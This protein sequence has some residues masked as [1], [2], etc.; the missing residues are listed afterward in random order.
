[1]QTLAEV[2]G[3]ARA[4][5]HYVFSGLV[6]TTACG[7]G[8]PALGYPDDAGAPLATTQIDGNLQ[9][10]GAETPLAPRIDTS[11]GWGGGLEG[12]LSAWTPAGIAVDAQGRLLVSGPVTPSGSPPQEVIH[13]LAPDGTPDTSF[14]SAGRAA[15]GVSASAWQQTLRALPDGRVGVIGAMSS[16]AEN[17]TFAARLLEDGSMDSAFHTE[18]VVAAKAGTFS[19]GLWAD[20]GAAFIFGVEATVSLDSGGT[21]NSSYGSVGTLPS[22]NAGALTEDGR[23][24][25]C[26]DHGIARYEKS[27]ALDLTFGRGGFVDISGPAGGAGVTSLRQLA[28]GVDGTIAAV[29]SH[30]DATSFYVD[31]ARLGPSGSLDLSY[32]QGGWVSIPVSSGPVGA[33]YL[34]DRRLLVWT[35]D[36]GLVLV[37]RNGQAHESWDLDVRGTVLAAAL[38]TNERLVMIGTLTDSPPFFHWF[39]RRF[40]LLDQTSPE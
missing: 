24:L 16:G 13:R 8:P 3:N 14:A 27:G 29:G 30:T 23:L 26:T 2:P 35:S 36:G 12:L 4:L 10:V 7:E 15:F 25:T 22:S 21:L 17:G 40:L 9:G 32:G 11:F 33:G 20:N 39:L 37:P 18:P 38:D 28:L 34:A 6:F 19:A 1:M 31:V 5:G